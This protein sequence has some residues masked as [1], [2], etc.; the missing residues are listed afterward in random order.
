[1]AVLGVR[2]SLGQAW[3]SHVP[4]LVAPILAAF[5]MS[6]IDGRAGLHDL[7]A[8]MIR[9]RVGAR[10]YLVAVS[11]LLILRALG[12]C[13]GGSRPGLAG[14]DRD[15]RVQRPARGSGSCNGTPAA[16]AE[17]RRRDRLARLRHARA[18]ENEEFA[19]T[20]VVVGLLWALWHVPSMFVVETYAKW[21]SEFCRCLRCG[22]SP[23]N[24]AR[25]GVSRVR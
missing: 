12:N 17:P 14:L 1:M 13:S 10:W 22:L 15:G 4:G 6:S 21:T 16:G 7:S 3:P 25:V 11:P 8:R 24:I 19:P 20:A 5:V 2:V 18:S 23:V 9:W